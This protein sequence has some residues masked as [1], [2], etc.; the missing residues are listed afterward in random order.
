MC[1]AASRKSCRYRKIRYIV[2]EKASYIVVSRGPCQIADD[3]IAGF[4]RGIDFPVQ[5]LAQRS[6]AG[7]TGSR[8]PNQSLD[9]RI[10]L[11][12]S[13]FQRIGAIVNDNYIRKVFAHHINQIFFRLAQLQ[14]MLTISKIIVLSGVIVIFPNEPVVHIG[15]KVDTFAA[16]TRNHDKRRI[17]KRLGIFDHLIGIRICRRFWK[18]PFHIHVRPCGALH[19]ASFPI[20]CIK[21]RKFFV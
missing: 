16:C 3:D 13:H 15:R 10:L 7:L 2:I 6:E 8:T 4:G 14:I 1:R 11:H 20:S 17:R 5:N 9:L 19:W 18:C 21:I 12:K